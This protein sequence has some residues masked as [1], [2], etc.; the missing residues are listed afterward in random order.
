MTCRLKKRQVFTHLSTALM[1]QIISWQEHNEMKY[2]TRTTLLLSTGGYW[3]TDQ[4]LLIKRCPLLKL[5]QQIYHFQK[6]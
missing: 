3:L 6:Y 1:A 2:K 4:R 5:H